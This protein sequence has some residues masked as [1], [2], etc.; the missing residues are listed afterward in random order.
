MADKA[1]GGFFVRLGGWLKSSRPTVTWIYCSAILFPMAFA[2]VAALILRYRHPESAQGSLGFFAVFYLSLMVTL[3]SVPR[4]II[5]ILL[6]WLAVAR[7]KPDWDERRWIRY[8][9][10]FLLMFLAVSAHALAYRNGFNVPWLISG[11]L[12]IALPRIAFPML[13]E[14][15]GKPA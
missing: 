12:S 4:S 15:L 7:F 2:L 14:G 10:L 13:R 3:A 1:G 9:G 6:I 5:P 11:W 8:V